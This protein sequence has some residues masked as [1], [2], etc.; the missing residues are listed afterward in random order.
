[1]NSVTN[2]NH[3]YCINKATPAGS[4]FYYA[5]LFVNEHVKA[6]LVAI[7]ALANELNDIIIECTDPGVA[8]IKFNWWLE[9]LS[10]LQQQPRHPVTKQ[11]KQLFDI[12]PA[13][14]GSLNQAVMN[15]EKLIQVPQPLQLS[16]ALQQSRQCEGV[17]WKLCAQSLGLNEPPVLNTIEQIAGVYHFFCCLQKPFTYVT[18][19]RCLIPAEY[20]DITQL[21]LPTDSETNRDQQLQFRQMIQTLITLNNEAGAS[22]SHTDRQRFLHGVILSRIASKTLREMLNTDLVHTSTSLTPIR[23][24][25]LA[26]WTKIT[27]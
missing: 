21:E 15:Y 2:S 24:L 14:L 7:H 9:E 5:C 22:L 13:L 25:L 20:L 16:E 12:D 19:S 8:K 10:R 1:M 27:H 3:Q 11:I 6:K 23:K 18:H 17:I 4:N 26:W